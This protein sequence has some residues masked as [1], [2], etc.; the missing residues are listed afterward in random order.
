[1]KYTKLLGSVALATLLAAGFTGC[2]S[3][4]EV[5]KEA[6]K[7]AAEISQTLTHAY[8]RVASVPGTS[9]DIV[10]IA[11]IIAKYVV[12]TDEA[13]V[14]GFPSNWVIAGANPK[15]GGT[16]ETED[17]LPIPVAE[18]T[19]NTVVYKSRVIEFCNGAYA[20]QATNTGQERGSALPCEV[21]VHSDGTNVYIDML[22]AS[23][24]FG[25][26]FPGTPDPDGKLEAM[27]TA[28]K[29]ELRA[30]IETALTDAGEDMTPITKGLGPAFLDAEI[31]AIK[32]DDIYQVTSYTKANG[33]TFTTTDAKELSE[34]IIELLGTPD[35]MA[36]TNVAGLSEGSAWRTGRAE[37]IAIPGVFVAEACSGKYAPMATRLG[38]EYITALPCEITSYLDRKDDTNN[39]ISVSILDPEFMFNTMFRGAVADAIKAG[40]L[41]ETEAAG[42]QTLAKVVSDDLN[43]ILDAAIEAQGLV[44]K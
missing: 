23:A 37:P 15:D 36:D 44:K 9:A 5:E 1:M 33:G 41:N 20:T 17:L 19:S 29:T 35:A 8:Q 4:D 16:Y 31:A 28:V 27:A 24:I 3:D 25:M 43:L 2:G 38:T 34:K 10:N 18:K 30:M 42:Y 12:N 6:E 7:D 14:L 32:N 39:T 11:E 13:A 26:F 40:D 21:S 22:D